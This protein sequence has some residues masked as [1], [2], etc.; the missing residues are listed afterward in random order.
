MSEKAPQYD[1]DKPQQRPGPVLK[2]AREKMELS[3]KDIASQLNLQVETIED[4]E[5]DRTEKFPAATYV[6]G[7]I[8]SFARIVKLDPDEMIRLFDNEP[9]APPEFVPDIKTT[10]QASSQDKPVRAVTYLVTFALALLLIAW[11]QSNYVVEK[12]EKNT[13][14]DQT[15]ASDPSSMPGPYP[16]PPVEEYNAVEDR[17]RTTGDVQTYAPQSSRLSDLQINEQ[18]A[19]TEVDE[20]I[21]N[22]MALS[23]IEGFEDTVPVTETNNETEGEQLAGSADAMTDDRLVLRLNGES[24]IEVYDSGDNRL[25]LGLAK[26]G[27]EI[28]LSG[29]APFSVL[30]GY[31]PAVELTFNGQL[32]DP[33]PYSNAGIARFKLGEGSQSN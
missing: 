4:I 30:L 25:Y 20:Q 6:R 31:S 1:S 16:E 18:A 14:V 11:L 32:F 22:N 29:I 19:M 27:E 26:A 7:Y 3:R 2:Q 9:M 33:Q 15:A 10:G 17:T 5:E 24:W 8:R 23:D 13:T 21:I 28:R 12:N